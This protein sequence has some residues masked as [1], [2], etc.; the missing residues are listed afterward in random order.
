MPVV[1]LPKLPKWRPRIPISTFCYTVASLVSQRNFCSIKYWH[2][3]LLFSLPR[4]QTWAI[5]RSPGTRR[6]GDMTHVLSDLSSPCEAH[7]L[8]WAWNPHSFQMSCALRY[9]SVDSRNRWTQPS[10]YADM[11]RQRWILG[12]MEGSLQLHVL[13]AFH[14]SSGRVWKLVT[15]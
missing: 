7:R 3:F 2:Y 12:R 10:N 13:C 1:L 8:Q 5:P 15:S 14:N 9:F 6:P 4:I 11:P